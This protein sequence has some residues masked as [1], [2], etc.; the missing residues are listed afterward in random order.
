MSLWRLIL[1]T[2]AHFRALSILLLLGAALTTAILTGSMMVGDSVRASLRDLAVARLGPVT[3][4]IVSNQMLDEGLAARI[5]QDRAVPKSANCVPLLSVRGRAVREQPTKVVAAGVQVMAVGRPLD[6]TRGPDQA[7]INST[8]A[9]ALQAQL[10]ADIFFSLPVM[11]DTARD[12]VLA[13]NKRADVLAARRWKVAQAAPKRTFAALFDLAGSQRAPRNAWVPLAELQH[14]VGQPGRV[15]TFLATGLPDNF[16]LE[17]TLKRQMT[18]ADYGLM[19]VESS[20][21][22]HVQLMA[23]SV[24]ILPPVNAAAEAAAAGLR[25]PT[26]QMTVNLLSELTDVRSGKTTYYTTGAGISALDDR[27]VLRDDE[28]A[29]NQWAAEELAARVGDAITMKYFRR[30]P[31]GNIV[32]ASSTEVKLKVARILPMRGLGA[33]RT[34]VPVFKGMTDAARIADWRPPVGVKIDQDKADHKYWDA[35]RAAPKVFLNF[36]M[37]TRLWSGEFVEQTALRIPAQQLKAFEADLLEHLKPA[38]IG[39]RVLP[40]RQAQ[41]AAAGGSTDFAE[42]FIAFSFFL[43]LAAMIVLAMLFRLSVEQRAR[44]LGLLA[45]IGFSPARLRRLMLGEG[46]LIGALG[47]LLG[48]ALAVAYT[49]LMIVGLRTWWIGA[50]G[51]SELSLH[52]NPETLATGFAISF[53]LITLTL[54]LT[55]R[56]VLK[57]QATLLLSGSFGTPVLR[58]KSRGLLS[59]ISAG[60]AILSAAGLIA[61]GATGYLKQADAFLSAGPLILIAGLILL[62]R[63]LAPRARAPVHALTGLAARSAAYRPGRSVMIASLI[64]FASFI[65]VTVASVKK[66]LFENPQQRP[67]PTGGFTLIMQADIPLLGDLNTANGRKN[68]GFVANEQDNPSLKGARF[69]NLRLWQ[70]QDISCLNMTQPTQPTIVSWPGALRNFF[71]IPSPAKGDPLPPAKDQAEASVAVASETA[72]YVLHKGL[73]GRIGITDQLGRPATLVLTALTGESIFQS[74]LLMN[75]ARF[76]QLFPLQAGYSIV[77]VECPPANAKELAQL[78]ERELGDYSVTVESTAARLARFQQ[79]QNTYLSTFQALGSLGLL[80]GTAGLGIVLIRSVYERRAELALLGAIGYA[81][82]RLMWLIVLENAGL[83]IGGL[84]IGTCSALLAVW[85]A[86]RHMNLASL[87]ATFGGILLCGLLVIVVT[88]RIAAANLGPAQLRAE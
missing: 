40:I 14:A 12:A 52:V 56:R 79:V 62:R 30:G 10:P 43:M 63:A 36:K 75:E 46:M 87:L 47:G 66:P 85:P 35:H 88:T 8:L 16:P 13:N 51:T 81:R 32:E 70:G 50:T 20:D 1:R 33:D 45:V 17:E 2:F 24:Y 82:G 54:L 26:Q 29:L 27:T 83:L 15:N 78:L 21:K 34:V 42:L 49:W 28:V 69:T 48:L 64:A 22:S 5:K 86:A 31:D 76:R 68:L 73:G 77:L 71:E 6:P 18:L 37:A 7:V 41:L 44:Q 39:I 72:E 55:V 60:L 19:L 80:L 4:A 9:E 25:L 65:L 61:A 74:E 53:I 67:S 84:L 3:H 57:A 11:E 23:R 38:D 58:R 59:A